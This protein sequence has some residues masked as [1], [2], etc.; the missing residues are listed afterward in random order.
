MI[1][2][3]EIDRKAFFNNVGEFKRRLGRTELMAVVKANAYGHGLL[4]IASL[5]QSAG[6]N[7]LG[8]NNLEEGL[9]LRQAGFKLK[10]LILGYVGLDQAEAAVAAD[11]RCVVYN[12]ENIRALARAARRLKKKAIVHLKIETGTNRQGIP[13]KSLGII[14]RELK[15]LPEIAVEGASSHFAN[16]E[17]TTDDFYPKYQL[18]NFVEAIR[19]LED[20][21]LPMAVKHLACSAAAILFPETYF[22][23]AR[24]GLGLYGL[25]PSKETLISCQQRGQEP[26]KLKPVLNWRT[27][28]AQIKSVPAGSYVGYGCTYRTTRRS[29]LA[30]IPVGYYDGY[31]RSLSNTAY[32]L[33]KGQ[34]AQIRGRVCM[35]FIMADVTDIPGVELE[36]RVTLL[37][38]DGQEKI[39]AEQLAGLA[40]TI[41]YE[42]ISRINPLTPRVIV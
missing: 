17:D 21:G 5:A 13:I 8:V 3:V 15:K 29:K 24:I 10:I 32:V 19:C 1:Q 31:D 41:N 20:N 39:T 38:S 26:L 22:N 14:T 25:W 35:D 2:W 11:L 7:W 4:E 42:I 30:V 33:I 28:V 12:L 34:R 23:L 6:L 36:D 40:G 18:A 27:R 9:A 16:I 37:G